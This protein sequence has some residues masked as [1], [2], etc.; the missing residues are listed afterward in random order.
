MGQCKEWVVRFSYRGRTDE[1]TIIVS[2]QAKPNEVV[3]WVSY[4][5][6]LC[7]YQ[8]P[9]GEVVRVPNTVI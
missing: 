2:R 1:L 4:D 5:L 6:F 9:E 3:D 8:L 7:M